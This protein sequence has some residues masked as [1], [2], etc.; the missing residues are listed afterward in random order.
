MANP[1]TFD[2]KLKEA[3]P[4]YEK[5]KN[6]WNRKPRN[7]VKTEEILNSLKVFFHFF[8]SNK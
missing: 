8:Y 3:L 1:A 7:I 5:L 4:L 2:A 6:E